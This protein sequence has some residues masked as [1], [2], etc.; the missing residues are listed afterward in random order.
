MR[1][2]MTTDVAIR[3]RVAGGQLRRPAARTIGGRVWPPAEQIRTEGGER[4]GVVILLSALLAIPPISTD[5]TLPALPSIAGAFGE[6]AGPIQ[7]VVALFLAGFAIGQLGYGPVS[8]RFGRRPV[9]IGGL[10]LYIAASAGSFG[11]TSLGWLLTG[12]FIQGLGA[13]AGPV[14]ARAVVRDVYAPARGARVLSLASVGMALAPGVGAIVGGLIVLTWQWR[15]VFAVL[16]SFGALVLLWSARFF[17]ETNGAPEPI[18]LSLGA[19]VR[20]YVAIATDRRFLGYVLPLGAGSVGLF[21]W[22][23]GS[24]F[25]LMTLGGLP[26]HRFGLAFAGVSLG[27]IFGA[28]LSARLVVR[29][30]IDR[31]VKTGLALYLSGAM[32]LVGVLLVGFGHPVGIVVPMALFQVGYGI[33]MPNTI[34]GAIAPFPRAAGAAAALAG[35]VQMAT[36]VLSGLTLGLLHDGSA[37]PMTLLVALSAV[38]AALFFALLAPRTREG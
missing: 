22:L 4:V 36:G 25:V 11:A 35:F 9:L 29:L 14:I 28:L 20:G 34:A 15:G 37:V 3:G 18:R 31:T 8:D 16:A 6:D 1:G 30:G 17:P 33:V 23:M 2:A 12:R 32:A 5:I 13:S 10:V 19:L 24:P 21:A 26:A 27:T 38:S 7:L